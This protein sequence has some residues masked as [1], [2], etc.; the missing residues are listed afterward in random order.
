VPS[1]NSAVPPV[2]AATISAAA[3]VRPHKTHAPEVIM[4]IH[5]PSFMA[6]LEHGQNKSGAPAIGAI[7]SGETIP[8]IILIFIFFFLPLAGLFVFAFFTFTVHI[9]C[10]IA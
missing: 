3:F 6:G 7:T 10:N 5:A 9:I 1:K 4:A 8:F 2:A